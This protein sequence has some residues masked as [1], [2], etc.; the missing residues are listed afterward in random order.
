MVT[1]RSYKESLALIYGTKKKPGIKAST[2]QRHRSSGGVNLPNFECYSWCF[3]L[4]SFAIWSNPETLV[5]WRP[6][7]ERLVQPYCLSNFV[8]SNIPH[9]IIKRDFGP[10]I[11]YLLMIWYKVNRFAKISKNFFAQ[12]PI[13]NNHSLLIEN[14]PIVFPKWSNRGVCVFRDIIGEQGLRAFHDLERSYNLTGTFY[15]Y[16]QL[17][18]A[19]RAQGVPWGIEFENHPLHV[20]VDTKGKMNGIVSVLYKFITKASY[21]PLPLFRLWKT[22][23]NISQDPD[24]C[25]VWSNILL[26]SRNPDHQMIHYRLV[27][28]SYLTLRRLQ[29]MN[30]RDNPFCDFCTDNTVA[31]FYHMV[32]QCPEVNRFWYSIS[33]IL[34]NIVKEP[35][36]FSPCLF[37]LNDT[38]SLKLTINNLRLLLAGLTAA[39]RMIVSC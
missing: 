33:S 28:R 19:M 39:K 17:R 38:S 34:S 7:E 27:H 15:F 11:S 18:A 30:F 32:W 24:W 20:I 29:Q 16:L 1:G 23:I 14:K 8:Y 2:L 10:I 13:F 31:T 3:V 26:S 12:S 21:K 6:I 4:R 37:L 5:S 22:D 25:T 36:P 9:N 35:I